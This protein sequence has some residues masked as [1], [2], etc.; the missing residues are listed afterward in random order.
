[1]TTAQNNPVSLPAGRLGIVLTID[2][3]PEPVAIKAKVA[4]I[5]GL[6]SNAD[7]GT[8]GRGSE[9]EI[10]DRQYLV[11]GQIHDARSPWIGVDLDGTLAVDVGS[12][13]WDD[14][15]KPKIGRPVIGMLNRVKRWVACGRTVKIFTARASSPV[16]VAA[17][18]RWLAQWGLPDLEVTNVKDFNM[19]ELWDDRCIRVDKNSGNPAL[20]V[21]RRKPGVSGSLH[22]L[23]ASRNNN[24]RLFTKLSRAFL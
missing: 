5:P 21:I 23:F 16:Q 22:A 1:M 17:I 4:G 8:P 6:E 7:T 3:Q 2:R 10:F 11:Q 13:P 19:V 15:G 9:Q 24:F 20:A 14:R 18:R 12:L